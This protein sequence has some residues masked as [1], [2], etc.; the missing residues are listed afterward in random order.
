MKQYRNG[1]LLIVDDDAINRAILRKIFMG[2]FQVEEA[3]NGRQG[4]KKILDSGNRFCAVLLD[5][6]MPEMESRL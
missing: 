1:K 5:V 2:S 3:E 4:L 6:M